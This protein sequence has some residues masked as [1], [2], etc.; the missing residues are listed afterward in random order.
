MVEPSPLRARR[1]LTMISIIKG[2]YILTKTDIC[3]CKAKWPDLIIICFLPCM[4]SFIR[5][6]WNSM[7]DTSLGP[8]QWRNSSFFFVHK[9]FQVVTRFERILIWESPFRHVLK[10]HVQINCFELS[11][12]SVLVLMIETDN[13]CHTIIATFLVWEKTLKKSS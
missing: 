10:N 12:S 5:S 8:H 1:L 2:I 6:L 4:A 9:T 3:C 11:L 13:I 7:S